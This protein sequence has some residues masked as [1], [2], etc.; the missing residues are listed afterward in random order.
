MGADEGK[1]NSTVSGRG[2]NS[3]TWHETCEMGSTTWAGG[4]GVQS[5]C[6][7]NLMPTAVC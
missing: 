2:R 7:V 4:H 1:R 6:L 3:T 5:L